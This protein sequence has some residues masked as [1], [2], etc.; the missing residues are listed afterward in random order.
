MA[1]DV[2]STAAEVRRTPVV[3]AAL[4]SLLA[5]SLA[6][7]SG[8]RPGPALVSGDRAVKERAEEP[9]SGSYDIRWQTEGMTALIRQFTIVNDGR[10]AEVDRDL[11]AADSDTVWHV[12]VENVSAD[13]TSA[14]ID[15][16]TFYSG[17]EAGREALRDGIRELVEPGYGRNSFERRQR[18]TIAPSAVIML[19]NTGDL[20]ADDGWTVRVTRDE[21]ARLFIRDP[22]RFEYQTGFLM[23]LSQDNGH[24]Q[25]LVEMYGP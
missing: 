19:N 10:R 16:R 1:T 18:I 14:E 12:R 6:G 9:S 15:V 21:F 2:R 8:C 4:G 25:Y 20:S 7:A 24:I 3:W 17:R 13:G 11:A 22:M 5:L 23:L